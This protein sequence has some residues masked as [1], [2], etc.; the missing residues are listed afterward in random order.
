MK[1]YAQGEQVFITYGDHSNEHLLQYYG[2]VDSDNKWDS[3]T[4]TDFAEALQKSGGLSEEALSRLVTIGFG[5][6]M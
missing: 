2:F 5:R 1:P 6:V 3:Y 4:F